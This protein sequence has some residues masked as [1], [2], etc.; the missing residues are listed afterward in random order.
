M[1]KKRKKKKKNGEPKIDYEAEFATVRTEIAKV[2]KKRDQLDQRKEVIDDSKN[3]FRRKKGAL[4]QQLF[5]QKENFEEELAENLDE[6]ER[7]Y[8]TDQHS[9]NELR[10]KNRELRILIAGTDTLAQENDTLRSRIVVL[11]QTLR[12]Q[13]KFFESQLAMRHKERFN[14]RLSMERTFRSTLRNAK[15]TLEADAKAEIERESREAKINNVHLKDFLSKQSQVIH[16]ECARYNTSHEDLTNLKIRTDLSESR[17]GMQSLKILH[18]EENNSKYKRQIR[19]FQE[20]L[21]MKQEQERN[22][23]QK[24]AEIKAENARIESENL[25]A[26]G[27]I[28]KLMSQVAAL[29][30]KSRSPQLHRYT[31]TKGTDSSSLRETVLQDTVSQKKIGQTVKSP[32][33]A[34]PVDYEQMWNSAARGGQD[35]LV[36]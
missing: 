4:E 2:T 6:F 23:L 19:S 31:S 30:C 7:Q 16:K 36:F 26:D 8:F 5:E 35:T 3:S 25:A 21:R 29:S 15:N 33:Q 14:N 20:D 11:D 28:E 22:L 9:I 27:V 32:L 13:S 18:L 10:E 12:R 1:P 34:S 17:N 24:L